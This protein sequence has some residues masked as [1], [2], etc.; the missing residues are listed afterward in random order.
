MGDNKDAIMLE[1]GASSRL[2]YD[3]NLRTVLLYVYGSGRGVHEVECG[4]KCVWT[5]LKGHDPSVAIITFNGRESKP[6]NSPRSTIYLRSAC[7]QMGA[8]HDQIYA[9]AQKE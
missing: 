7:T 4:M 2:R 8:A 6:W 5:N 9:H 1:R 3:A